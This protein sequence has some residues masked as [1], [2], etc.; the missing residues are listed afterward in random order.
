VETKDSLLAE[1]LAGQESGQG[2]DGT[3]VLVLRIARDVEFAQLRLAE[4]N[5]AEKIGQL[6]KKGGIRNRKAGLSNCSK[7]TYCL[8]E[9]RRVL[10]EQAVASPSNASQLPGG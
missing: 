3:S 7:G 8:L 6:E 9:K 2:S 5:E 4:M 10:R 1:T